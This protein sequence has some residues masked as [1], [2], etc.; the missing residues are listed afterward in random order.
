MMSKLDLGSTTVILSQ[1]GKFNLRYETKG[2]GKV[3]L[4]VKE[5]FNL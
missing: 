3:G 2:Q 4:S 1:I 5:S